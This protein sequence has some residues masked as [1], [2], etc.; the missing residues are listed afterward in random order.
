MVVRKD[1]WRTAVLKVGLFSAALSF[2]T[3]VS[4][5]WAGY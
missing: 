2:S 1:S 5:N 4:L 3:M